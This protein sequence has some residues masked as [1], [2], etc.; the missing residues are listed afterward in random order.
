METEHQAQLPPLT[1][2]FFRFLYGGSLPPLKNTD[3]K[4]PPLSPT[5]RKTKI[6][7]PGT[8]TLNP[9]LPPHRSADSK[10]NGTTHAPTHHLG[11]V[12]WGYFVP[13]LVD[14]GSWG[15]DQGRKRPSTSLSVA[16][17]THTPSFPWRLMC[18]F[19]KNNFLFKSFFFIL[20]GVW[21]IWPIEFS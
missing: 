6:Y 15:V 17:V 19:F 12:F 13:A 9:L 14:Q 10:C 4:E 11:W 5:K 18:M 3:E 1:L 16:R 2:G 8:P 21:L 20:D 7:L